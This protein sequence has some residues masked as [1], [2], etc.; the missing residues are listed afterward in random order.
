M[1]LAESTLRKMHRER[2]AK[3]GPF[4]GAC[5]TEWPCDAITVLDEY[6]RIRAIL[7]RLKEKRDQARGVLHE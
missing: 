4:C 6:L 2:P 7:V 5:G 3:S 1:E